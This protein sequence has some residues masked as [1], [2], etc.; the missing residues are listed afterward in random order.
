MG[1]LAHRGVVTTAPIRGSC[2]QCAHTSSTTNPYFPNHTELACVC[3]RRLARRCVHVQGEVQHWKEEYSRLKS[4][5]DSTAEGCACANASA[6]LAD[7]REVLIVDSSDAER[8]KEIPTGSAASPEAA[9]GRNLATG[10]IA[11]CSSADAQRTGEAVLNVLQHLEDLAME[12]H[13][14]HPRGQHL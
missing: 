6:G 2:H 1:L 9:E 3:A 5:L 4:Q 14:G 8:N 12:E 13:P 7:G 11:S 10:H